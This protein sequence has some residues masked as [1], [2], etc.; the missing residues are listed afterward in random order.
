MLVQ[1]KDPSFSPD[2]YTLN[3]INGLTS[4]DIAW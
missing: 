3:T 4:A 1:L 2:D